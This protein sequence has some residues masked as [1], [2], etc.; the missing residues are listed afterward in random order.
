M[1]DL[2]TLVR[3]ADKVL[4]KKPKSK[5]ATPNP[6]PLPKSPTPPDD[7]TSNPG[8]ATESEESRDDIEYQGVELG[9]ALPAGDDEDDSDD[10]VNLRDSVAS[11]A[12]LLMAIFENCEKTYRRAYGLNTGAK[13]TGVS[14]ACFSPVSRLTFF[15]A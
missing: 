13:A 4:G 1:F 7:N 11:A 8:D 5:K 2:L 6:A 10:G 15:L 12:N 9:L 14:I 3:L